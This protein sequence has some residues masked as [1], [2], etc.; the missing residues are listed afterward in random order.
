LPVTYLTF[1]VG[2]C[3]LAAIPP[4]AGF[5]SKDAIIE[6]VHLSTIPGAH[7]AYYCLLIG[8]FVTSY[9]IFRCFFL[10]FHTE[11]RFTL[12]PAHPLKEHWAMLIPLIVLAI[13]SVMLGAWLFQDFLFKAPG[14][15]SSSITVLPQ[16]D[17]LAKLGAEYQGSYWTAL[18]S[19]TMHAFSSLVFWLAVGGVFFAWLFNVVMP[20]VP[21]L[22][23]QRLKWLYWIL[24]EKY[25]FDHF[26]ELVFQ[27]G[28]KRL[29]NAFYHYGDMK[30]I[31]HFMVDGSGRSVERASKW[32]RYL[33]SGYLTHYVLA[34]IIGLIAFLAWMI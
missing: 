34:M 16:Y 2:A 24:R 27:R 11:Q 8:S 28:S 5:Y 4:F 10:A 19:I 1:L 12:D 23:Q 26:N 20:S 13:P 22:M 6:A 18:L 3:A 14:V 31:D 29:S 25:G 30:V 32:L 17:V 9:Y 7:Y 15:L 33:Q 21:E